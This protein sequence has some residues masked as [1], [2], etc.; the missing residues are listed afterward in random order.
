LEDHQAGGDADG[1]SED[2]DEGKDL[3]FPEVSDGYDEKV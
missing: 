2:I 3:V 1:E